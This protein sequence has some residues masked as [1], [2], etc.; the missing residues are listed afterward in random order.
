MNW[1]DEAT[2]IVG[3][4]KAEHQTRFDSDRRTNLAKARAEVRE[5]EAGVAARLR[6]AGFPE[7]DYLAS[8]WQDGRQVSVWLIPLGDTEQ[9]GHWAGVTGNGSLVYLHGTSVD[10]SLGRLQVNSSLN[11][12]SEFFDSALGV[13]QMRAIGQLLDTCD[14]PRVRPSWMDYRD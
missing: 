13:S 3:Q 10:R 11:I 4:R 12:E 9:A 5:S 7:N 1:N 2:R 6:A 14:K 8:C